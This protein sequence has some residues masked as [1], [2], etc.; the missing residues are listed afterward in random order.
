MEK[1]QYLADSS[2]IYATPRL[3][4]SFRRNAGYNLHV[5]MVCD[6]YEMTDKQCGFFAGSEASIEEMIFNLS[7]FTPY[8]TIFTHGL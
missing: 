7:W 1:Y 5:C 2:R 4:P 8:I 6:G 3:S